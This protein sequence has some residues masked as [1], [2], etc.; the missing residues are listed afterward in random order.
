MKII[1]LVELL[2]EEV[3]WRG[4]QRGRGREGVVGLEGGVIHRTCERVVKIK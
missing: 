3:E 2:E 4:F 1:I